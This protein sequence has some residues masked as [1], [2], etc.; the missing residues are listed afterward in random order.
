M[1]F[2]RLF[3]SNELYHLIFFKKKYTDFKTMNNDE[4]V[5]N[6]I[7]LIHSTTQSNYVICSQVS[8]KILSYLSQIQIQDYQWKELNQAVEVKTILFLPKL[9]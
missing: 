4:I 7:S 9:K 2:R 5:S 6:I 1:K 3:F 8:S